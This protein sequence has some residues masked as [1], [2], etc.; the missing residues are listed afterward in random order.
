MTGAMG[1][2]TG[3]S[4][5]AL[6]A[7]QALMAL[8]ERVGG[9]EGAAELGQEDV[10]RLLEW[11]RWSS[12]EVRGG[13]DHYSRVRAMAQCD[14]FGR[15]ADELARVAEAGNAALLALAASLRARSLGGEAPADVKL[16]AL[17]RADR[18]APALDPPRVQ[19]EQQIGFCLG[20]AR[21]AAQIHLA[22][23]GRV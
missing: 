18:P 9:V 22:A 23:G 6:Q 16:P 21:A 15:V 2:G 5:A 17:W 3:E 7:L 8:Q 4:P 12:R 13:M 20:L 14:A 10:A 19:R 11:L 1:G